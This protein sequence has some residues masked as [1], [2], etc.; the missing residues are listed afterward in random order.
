MSQ[1]G[2]RNAALDA[3]QVR[4]CAVLILCPLC[5]QQV[6]GERPCCMLLLLPKDHLSAHAWSHL[7]GQVLDVL[8]NAPEGQVANES[9]T[10]IVAHGGVQVEH[11]LG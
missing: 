1:L 10:H 9:C 11:A 8:V 2:G 3:M 4:G 6:L 5:W 7:A